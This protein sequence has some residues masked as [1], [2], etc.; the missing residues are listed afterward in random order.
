MIDLRSYP[1]TSRRITTV[2]DLAIP[3]DDETILIFDSGCD[4]ALANGKPW[5]ILYRTGKQYTVNS[6]YKGLGS[7]THLDEVSAAT[8]VLVNKKVSFIGILNNAIRNPS[9]QEVESLIPPAQARAAGH[10]VDDVAH[11][12]LTNSGASGSQ[13]MK[14]DGQEYP[15]NFDG[16]KCYW[17]IRFPSDAEWETLPR[18][19]LTSPRPYTP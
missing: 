18:I 9:E 16:Y 12:H 1:L 11:R 13:C 4:Q 10:L 3:T 2:G 19:D 14:I 8:T 7:I 17:Q 5:K 6:A 15:L